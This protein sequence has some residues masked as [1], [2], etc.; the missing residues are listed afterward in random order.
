[1]QLVVASAAAVK[2]SSRSPPQAR[3]VTSLVTASSRYSYG[4]VRCARERGAAVSP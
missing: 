3:K 4:I 2:S 1:M